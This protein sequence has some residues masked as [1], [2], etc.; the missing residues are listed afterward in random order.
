M[1]IRVACY[2]HRWEL[3]SLPNR[4]AVCQHTDHTRLLF[5][6]LGCISGLIIWQEMVAQADTAYVFC[7]KRSSLIVSNAIPG[8]KYMRLP[9]HGHFFPISHTIDRLG[10]LPRLRVTIFISCGSLG[11]PPASV[12]SMASSNGLPLYITGPRSEKSM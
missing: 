6:S 9:S 3:G 5:G 4:T 10:V 2:S 1:R 12:L 7:K 11:V 8:P